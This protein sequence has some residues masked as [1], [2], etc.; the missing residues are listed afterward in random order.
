MTHPLIS[1]EDAARYEGMSQADLLVMMVPEEEQAD[2]LYSL[3]G[4]VDRGREIFTARLGRSRDAVCEAYRGSAGNTGNSID[5]IVL[6]ATALVGSPAL[7]GVPVLAFCALVIKMG[8]E[9]ICP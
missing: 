6:L 7:A 2:G 5:L 9:N 1:A 3:Q 8:L 4:L